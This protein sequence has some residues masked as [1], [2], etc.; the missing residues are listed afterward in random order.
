M[1]AASPSPAPFSIF[2]CSSSLSFF[3]WAETGFA[4]FFFVVVVVLLLLGPKLG[5]NFF[6]FFWVAGRGKSEGEEDEDGGGEMGAQRRWVRLGFFSFFF[7]PSSSAGGF[8]FFLL[9]SSRL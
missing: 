3:S 1:G 9:P 5:L 6:F 7:S 8:N 2:F 4:T